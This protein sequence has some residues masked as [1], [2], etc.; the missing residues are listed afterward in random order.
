MAGSTSYS[1]CPK[2][3]TVHAFKKNGKTVGDIILSESFLK[4]YHL[5]SKTYLGYKIHNNIG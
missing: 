4:Y 2:V 3:T 1:L 5:N